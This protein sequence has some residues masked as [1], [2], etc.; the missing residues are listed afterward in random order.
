MLATSALDCGFPLLLGNGGR[1]FH[2][3][4]VW[5]YT[6]M[7]LREDLNMLIL[8]AREAIFAL[9]LDDITV[10]KAMVKS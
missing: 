2:E 3:K 7:L 5:N 10:K 4:G 1:F 6:T 9:N 8:G